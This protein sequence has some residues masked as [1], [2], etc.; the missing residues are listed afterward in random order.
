MRSPRGRSSPWSPTCRR[1]RVRLAPPDP[2][3]AVTSACQPS[4]RGGAYARSGWRWPPSWCSPIWPRWCPRRPTPGR[5][6][7]GCRYCSLPSPS[8]SRYG[9]GRP[10]GSRCLRPWRHRGARCH[11]RPAAPGRGARRGGAGGWTPGPAAEGW[12]KGTA[13]AGAQWRAGVLGLLGGAVAA[14]L[15]VAVS[16]RTQDPTA[17]VA[18]VLAGVWTAAA[19]LFAVEFLLGLPPYVAPAL[20]LGATPLLIRA[21]PGAAL[22]IS[23]EQVLDMPFLAR[24]A[25]SV[26]G[27]LPKSPGRVRPEHVARRIRQAEHRERAGMIA[28]SVLVAATTPAVLAGYEPGGLRGWGTVA[29]VGL[30]VVFLTLAPRSFRRLADKLP[31]RV[32]LFT[33]LAQLALGAHQFPDLLTWGIVALVVAVGFAYLAV[34]I[35]RGYRSVRFSRLGDIV[36]GLT[37]GLALPAALIAAGA[38]QGL[39]TV[40]GG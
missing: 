18:A 15:R 1:V 5:L 24:T 31:P 20:V 33:V 38:V 40:T 12:P 29:L 37:V 30:V 26:R 8:C 2:E 16:R 25:M 19:A 22:D 28:A 6:P 34:P 14:V 11:G 39:Q 17:G 13:V 4:R 36:E 35:A 10:D 23:E 32:A 3:P 7:R 9:R 21:M 27:V